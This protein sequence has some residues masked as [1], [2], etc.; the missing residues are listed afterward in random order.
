MGTA[1]DRDAITDAIA[2]ALCQ[3]REQS[4]MSLEEVASAAELPPAT[5]ARFESGGREVTLP[6]FSRLGAVLGFD[7]FVVMD[8]VQVE[9]FGPPRRK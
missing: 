8:A 7:P 2:A 4:G 6:V 5:L 3:A 9:A 1:K